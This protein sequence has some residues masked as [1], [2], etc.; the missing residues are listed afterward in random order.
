M[1][2]GGP[3]QAEAPPDWNGTGKRPLRVAIVGDSM[4]S[5]LGKGLKGWA[6]SRGDVITY[7]VATLGCPLSRGGTRRSPTGDDWPVTEECEWW[8]DPSS[9]RA[10]YLSMFNPDVIVVQDAMNELPD[11][12]LPQWNEYRHTG[13]PVFDR[14]LLDEY[15]ALIDTVASDTTKVLFLNA[16]CVNWSLLGR[17][18]EYYSADGEGDR[19]VQSLRATAA[20][21][22]SAGATVADF[23][24]HICPDGKFT[25]TVDGV[26]DARPDGYHLSDEAS[27]AVADK[28]LG[29]LV[30]D[31]AKKLPLS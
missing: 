21:V 7:S 29:P 10:R 24:S 3:A 20:G 6:E 1:N 28:W 30:L 18:Y 5:N 12:K 17:G 13:E 22:A 8:A 14:W 16:V 15:T 27:R 2:S 4:A 19:R 26:D 31:T 25:Q 23:F 11:R 9:D